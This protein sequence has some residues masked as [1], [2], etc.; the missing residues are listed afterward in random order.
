MHFGLISTSLFLSTGRMFSAHSWLRSRGEK[1]ILGLPSVTVP[2]TAILS[3]ESGEKN[4]TTTM[5]RRRKGKNTKRR[6]RMCGDEARNRRRERT[7]K[8][9][10][11]G[12][13]PREKDRRQKL[14]EVLRHTERGTEKEEKP[15]RVGHLG[16]ERKDKA[17]LRLVRDRKFLRQ[18]YPPFHG[19]SLP[20][21]PT[22]EIEH[23]FTEI[24][25]FIFIYVSHMLR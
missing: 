25:R 1:K 20:C 5:K 12:E 13:G 15:T 16:C 21:A 11:G 10:C 2:A 19:I 6:R 23:T 8:E 9:G 7:T 17:R 22:E 4:E 18:V 14:S 3:E 24:R